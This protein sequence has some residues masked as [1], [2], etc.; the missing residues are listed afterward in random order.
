MNGKDKA[1]LFLRVICGFTIALGLYG[2]VVGLMSNDK[3]PLFMVD[4][5]PWVLGASC[6]YMGLRYWRRI[7][8]MQQTVTYSPGFSWSNFWFKNR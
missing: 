7:P 4:V 2:I 5:P 3:I 8:E 1:I 6:A